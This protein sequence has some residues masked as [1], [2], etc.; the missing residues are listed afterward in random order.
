MTTILSSLRPWLSEQAVPL[1]F[2]GF[3]ALMGIFVLY[4]SMI[5]RRSAKKRGRSGRTEET[6]ADE[7]AGYGYDA[8]IARLTYRML[9]DRLRLDYPIEPTDDLERDLGLSPDELM[10]VEWALLEATGREHAP[11][12]QLEP[13]VTVAHLVRHVETAPRRYRTLHIA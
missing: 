7:M 5:S 6:F 12:L 4:L 8:D 9:T 1:L 3:A 11:G 2:V 10:R 13:V